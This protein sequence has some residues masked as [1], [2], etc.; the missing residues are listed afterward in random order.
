MI[1]V[2][3]IGIGLA[4]IATAFAAPWT[5]ARLSAGQEYPRRGFVQLNI[6]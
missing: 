6:D 2:F 3:F 4:S 5:C 1:T